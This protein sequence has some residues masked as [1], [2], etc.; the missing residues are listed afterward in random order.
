V[1]E[2]VCESGGVMDARVVYLLGVLEYH[3]PWGWQHFTR[4][5]GNGFYNTKNDIQV[6]LDT[7]R[8]IKFGYPNEDDEFNRYYHYDFD[9]GNHDEIV[10]NMCYAMRRLLITV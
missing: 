8:K 7:W 3:Y 9:I 1:G 6:R 5:W 2:R 10:R 4:A